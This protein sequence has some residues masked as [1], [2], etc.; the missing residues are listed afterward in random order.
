MSY[1]EFCVGRDDT[2]LHDLHIP[3]LGI[4]RG[5]TTAS[6][7]S[8]LSPDLVGLLAVGAPAEPRQP[9]D[10]HGE[11]LLPGDRD[12]AGGVRRGLLHHQH[13]PGRQGGH[14]VVNLQE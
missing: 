10:G 9:L 6:S 5:F 3:Q 11:G 2:I 1:Y 13:G 14:L 12:V 8:L 7:L 4:L